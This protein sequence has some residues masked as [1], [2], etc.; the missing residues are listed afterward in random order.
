MPQSLSKIYVHLVFSTKGRTETLPTKHLS[1]VHSYVAQ[2][3]N[4]T[5]CPA[6]CVGGI[7]NHIHILFV[8]NKTMA[9]SDIVGQIKSCTTRWI[10]QKDA[11]PLH[12]FCWQ[13]GYGAFSVSQSQ[14]PAVI[15]YI[16]RQEEHHRKYTF[17]DEFRRFCQLYD[18][19]IDERYAWD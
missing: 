2:I 18:A 5:K 8:L 12:Y 15:N 10:N 1:E 3:L 16:Q 9:L 17:Q 19:P 7:A 6:L 4:N 13:D 11:N 14:V